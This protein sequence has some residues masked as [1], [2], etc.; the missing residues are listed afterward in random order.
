MTVQLLALA[1]EPGKNP[2]TLITCTPYG[3]NTHRL[4]VRGHRIPYSPIEDKGAVPIFE[5]QIPLQ[6]LIPCVTLIALL[7]AW[8]LYKRHRARA[9]SRAKHS[10]TSAKNNVQNDAGNNKD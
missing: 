9:E 2:V 1:I 3:V 6:Y 10:S 7:I 5:V 8:K 4:L